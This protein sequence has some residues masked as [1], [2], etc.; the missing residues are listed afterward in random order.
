[1]TRGE[2][3][4]QEAWLGQRAVGVETMQGSMYAEVIVLAAGTWATEW[5]A[6]RPTPPI[7]PVTGQMM[8]LQALTGL[9]L[10][11]TVYAS[12]VGGILPKADGTIY[13]GATPRAGGI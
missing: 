10:R 3:N 2:S 6:S 4:R 9:H 13:V 11:H 1:M 5:Y 12:G 8:A 7:F